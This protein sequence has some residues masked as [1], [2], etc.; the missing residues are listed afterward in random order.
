[1]QRLTVATTAL[2]LSVALF[3]IPG[4]AVAACSPIL[5]PSSCTGP[6]GPQ[7]PAGPAGPQGAQGPQGE[8]GIQGVQGEVGPAGPAGPQGEQGVAGVDGKD[9]KDGK[10]GINGTNGRDFDMGNAL[11][12]SAA[13][14]VPVW[15]GDSEKV[16]I[17]GG[18]GFSDGGDTAIGVTG[19]VRLDKNLAGFAGAALDTN[20][21]N[22][23][24]K[25]G[26]SYGW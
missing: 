19:I 14:S 5:N 2:A 13:L 25:V 4:Q 6:A 1:M 11:A 15:L 24:G 21:G 9:G 20:G 23:A 22:F 18:L 8:Q 3:S 17:S 7:G 16:R 10:D 12:I 26:V